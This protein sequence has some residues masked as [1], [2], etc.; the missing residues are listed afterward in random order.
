[1]TTSD[2]ENLAELIEDCGEL[3]TNLRT[4]DRGSSA[5]PVPRPAAWSVNERCLAAVAEL[6]AYG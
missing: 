2:A 4:A 6:D 5:I 1:V 3:P